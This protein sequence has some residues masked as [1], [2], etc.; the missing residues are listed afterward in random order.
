MSRIY[1]CMFSMLVSSLNHGWK[2]DG[3]TRRVHACVRLSGV[4][5]VR[6]FWTRV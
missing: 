6:G 1:E 3:W 2:I 5:A 4:S